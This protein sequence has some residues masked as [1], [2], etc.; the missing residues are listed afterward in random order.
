MGGVHSQVLQACSPAG[1]QAADQVCTDPKL[2]TCVPGSR[3]ADQSVH[4]PGVSGLGAQ[5]A[6]QGTHPPGSFGL[7]PQAARPLIW[8]SINRASGVCWGCLPSV[9]SPRA[10]GVGAEEAMAATENSLNSH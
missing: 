1:S 7:Y 6:D 4:P 3:A 10:E 2:W 9:H 8:V 5:V